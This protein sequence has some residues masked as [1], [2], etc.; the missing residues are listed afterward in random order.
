MHG[1]QSV[2]PAPGA[3][4]PPGHGVPTAEPAGQI[5]PGAQ[6]PVHAALDVAPIVDEKEPAGHCE[7]EDESAGQYE[8][9]GHTTCVAD[10][11]PG[12]QYQ[13]AAQPPEHALAVSR[14]PPHRPPSQKPEQKASA[15]PAKPYVP[16]GQGAATDVLPA[17]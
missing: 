3:Y 13:P 14:A 2:A 4:V 7:G 10:E 9:A 16:G 17:Q 8:P 15:W 11:L 1:R 12:G 6:T 5:E